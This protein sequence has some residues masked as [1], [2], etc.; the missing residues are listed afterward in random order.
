MI[1]VLISL[2][3]YDNSVVSCTAY[4][5][6][7]DANIYRKAAGNHFKLVNGMLHASDI[8]QNHRFLRS[9]LSASE[10]PKDRVRGKMG[11]L[12][13]EKGTKLEVYVKEVQENSGCV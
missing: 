12:V 1:F 13:I 10:I 8:V 5:A 7:V 4:A 2:C 3:S 11:E 9:R 6:Y